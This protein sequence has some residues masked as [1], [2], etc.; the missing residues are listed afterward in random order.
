MTTMP[1][2]SMA[3]GT[4]SVMPGG[5]RYFYGLRVLAYIAVLRGPITDKE[6]TEEA[7]YVAARLDDCGFPRDDNLIVKVLNF[8]L[9]IAVPTQDFRKSL[10]AVAGDKRNFTFVAATLNEITGGTVEASNEPLL[11][12]FREIMT[13]GEERGSIDK[14]ASTLKESGSAPQ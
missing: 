5:W 7:V 2:G 6:K 3:G 9:A 8:A 4:K 10:K 12:A 13:V 14:A 1:L 11:A